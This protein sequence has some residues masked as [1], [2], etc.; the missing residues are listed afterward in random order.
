M[1]RPADAALG[2]GSSFQELA[3]SK[4]VRVLG[5]AQAAQVYGETLAAAG[6]SGIGSADD[7]YLFAAHLS[8]RGGFAAAVGGLLSVAAVLRG[9]AGDAP[10]SPGK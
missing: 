7:L 10:E 1:S 2:D 3:Q 4:L 5:P 9:A 6:L 8:K